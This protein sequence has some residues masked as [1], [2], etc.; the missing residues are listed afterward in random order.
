MFKY[1]PEWFWVS[2]FIVLSL[3]CTYLILRHLALQRKFTAINE[4]MSVLRQ[5]EQEL[6]ETRQQ[7]QVFFHQSL[8]GFFFCRFDTPQDWKNSKNKEEILDYVVNTQRYT[9]VNDTLLKQYSIAREDFLKLTTKDV[10]AHDLE[11]GRRLRR[12]L[13]D[14]GHMS[15]ETYEITNGTP[16]WFEGD[17][18]CLYD[19]Q[20]RIAGFFGIQRDITKRKQ[21][22]E[23]LQ[24]SEERYR[25]ISDLST[26]YIFSAIVA[27]DGKIANDWIS[28]AF[29]SI[30]GYT[31]EE[32]DAQGGWR[33]NLHP[34]DIEIDN[35]ILDKLYSNQ[36]AHGEMR[37]IT[38]SGKIRWIRE[39]TRP[40]WD[41]LDNRLIGIYGAVQSIDDQKEY[42]EK[43][44][45]LNL[46]LEKRV[47]ERTNQLKMEKAKIERIAAEV[48]GLRKLSDFLQSSETVE[49]AAGIISQHVSALFAGAS[50]AL[51]LADGTSDLH[52]VSHWGDA[53]TE[54]LIQ[55]NACWGMRRGR[56][57]YK[58]KGDVSPLCPHFSDSSAWQES[59][60][61]P[62][63]A[64]G[65]VIGMITLQVSTP[66]GDVYFS[67]ELQN[68]ANTSADTISLALANL[69]LRERLRDQSI[70][71]PLTGLFNRRF[72]EETL[73]RE[74]QRANRSQ[75]PLCVIM[76]EIDDFKQYNNNFGHEAGNYVLKKISDSIRLKLRASDFPCRY[77]GDE[78]TLILPDTSLDV[79]AVRAEELRKSVEDLTLSFNN[80]VLGLVTVRLG[81]AVYPQHGETGESVLQAAD[82]ASYKARSIGKNCVVK[83]G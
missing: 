53:G 60:C 57:Y 43:I 40:V 27:K 55:P 64:Q 47:E 58:H 72:M 33:F 31:R 75:R 48:A 25:L 2:E 80:Q 3:L 17:Y 30:S 1:I 6:L 36:R 44:R 23:A 10:F 18:S 78:F 51:Y 77:G 81:V 12:E 22:E 70:R 73:K 24:V 59:I 5:T 54:D 63:L 4:E 52:I 42:E 13:F 29:E 14:N 41:D 74:V 83:A 28:G 46:S 11:Q 65:E 32:F 7:L 38:K 34:D 15:F 20:G 39:Y 56:A 26:N 45:D 16:T 61:L 50:G 67:E 66:S 35:E 79:G 19:D 37:V 21:A 69:R 49:E 68:F 62:L 71:D 8:G 9:D 82:N 76:L